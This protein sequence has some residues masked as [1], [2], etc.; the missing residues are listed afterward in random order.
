MFALECDLREAGLPHLL[1]KNFSRRIINMRWQST[2]DLEE[3]ARL[4]SSGYLIYLVLISNEDAHEILWEKH[5]L[6]HDIEGIGR[7]GECRHKWCCTAVA[8]IRTVLI[9]QANLIQLQHRE[10]QAHRALQGLPEKRF[11]SLRSYPNKLDDIIEKR[12]DRL[13]ALASN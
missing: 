13:Y 3:N 10:E 8:D 2:Q 7:Y 12:A 4:E 9:R 6:M 11:P 1:A 5:L